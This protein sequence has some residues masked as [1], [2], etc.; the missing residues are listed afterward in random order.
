MTSTDDLQAQALTLLQELRKIG[1]LNY[2]NKVA[3]PISPDEF[4]GVIAI[5]EAL[6]AIEYDALEKL[7]VYF[8]GLY[9]PDATFQVR[10]FV[11]KIRALQSP[12]AAL[13]L[14]TL[15]KCNNDPV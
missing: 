1:G 2:Q 15:S 4:Y 3:F 6:P 13:A 11:F 5:L 10:E 12:P 9:K 7:A 8:S 14:A